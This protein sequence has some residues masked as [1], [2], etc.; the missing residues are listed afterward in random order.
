[1]YQ[2]SIHPIISDLIGRDCLFAFYQTY[3]YYLY[4]GMIAVYLGGTPGGEK[5]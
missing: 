5:R 4:G 3:S 1:M 2:L